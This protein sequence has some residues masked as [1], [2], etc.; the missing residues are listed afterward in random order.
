VVEE[1]GPALELWQ[2]GTTAPL[3]T[4]AGDRV[5]PSGVVI[6]GSAQGLDSA[7]L[8]QKREIRELHDVVA[9]READV[10]AAR[11]HQET[12]VD[13]QTQLENEREAGEAELLESEKVRLQRVQEVS[14][15]QREIEQLGARVSQLGRERGKL[16]ASL[17]GREE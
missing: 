11:E 17:G 3:V 15:L 5:E 16:E 10:A 1:L 9:A 6:G 8:Q 12:L 2:A 14:R 4:L 7:L 13:R